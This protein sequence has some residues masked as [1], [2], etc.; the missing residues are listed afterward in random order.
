M[1]ALIVQINLVWE[2]SGLGVW[3]VASLG[4]HYR[5][6]EKG[7]RQS[8]YMWRMKIGI[9]MDFL[10]KY[11][12]YLKVWTHGMSLSHDLVL[13]ALNSELYLSPPSKE[14]SDFNVSRMTYKAE[15]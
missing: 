7:A 1:H 5:A 3:N 8:K 6:Q 9:L 10:M 4:Q 12:L 2:C 15:L 13:N 14:A 11:L